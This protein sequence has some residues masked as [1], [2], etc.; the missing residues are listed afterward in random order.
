[1]RE[2]VES[3]GGSFELATSRLGT[4][5]AMTLDVEEIHES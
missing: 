5:L 2:R 4:K 1:M 3:L